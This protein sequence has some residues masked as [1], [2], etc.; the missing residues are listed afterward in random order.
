MLAEAETHSTSFLQK[1][2]RGE[3]AVCRGRGGAGG[4]PA[5]PPPSHPHPKALESPA[6]LVED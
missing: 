5:G 3:D 1:T 4:Q 6:L 2:P